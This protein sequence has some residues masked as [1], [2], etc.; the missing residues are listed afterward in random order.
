MK[1]L[2]TFLTLICLTAFV[3]AQ[4]IEDKLVD[5]LVEYASIYT[6]S[7]YDVDEVPS[8]QCQFGLALVL[9][10]ELKSL[11]A[12]DVKVDEHSYVY[13]TIKGN[14]ENAP[15]LFLSAHLDTSPDLDLQGKTPVP[16]VHE[17]NGGDLQIR[18]GLVLTPEKNEFLAD[19]AGGK[20]I[21]SDGN[22]LLGGDDKAGMSVVMTIA[23]T[24]LTNPS[25][26][27]GDVRIIFTPDEEI[28]NSTKYLTKKS[29][30]A[31]FGLVWI[32]TVSVV[33]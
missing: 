27:H 23:E 2:F 31:D 32:A 20:V 6:Q 25:I 9:A 16:V 10:D 3:H 33:L 28:G 29:I 22:T 19:A 7:E 13:A 30:A 12:Q 17:Y 21:T 1:K 26:Q 15:T 8:S 11:G 24:L 5:R 14:V 4:N 18:E